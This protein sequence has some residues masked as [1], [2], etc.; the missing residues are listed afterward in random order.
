[1]TSESIAGDPAFEDNITAGAGERINPAAVRSGGYRDHLARYLFA[2]HFVAGRSVADL[3]CGVGYGSNLLLAA[4]AARVKGIDIAPDAVATA[5]QHYPGPEF[6]VAAADRPLD[7]REFDV[8]VC[9]EGIE[10]VADPDRLLANMAGA[11]L[12]VVSSPNAEFFSGGFSGN[13]HH[14][15]E[16]T[17]AEFEAALSRHFS[18]V[19]MY[20]QWHHPDPLDLDR[21]L[22]SGL[23]AVVPVPLKAR[24]WSLRYRSRSSEPP[25]VPQMGDH[26]VNYRVLRAG[27]LVLA[28]LLPGLRYGKPADWVALCRR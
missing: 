10:H 24:V 20:F 15:R 7:L 22:M 19:R 2:A 21:S 17:R 9:L 1:M 28:R 25:V 11:D 6:E 26:R 27:T 14:L 23:K 18:Q 13:P 8:A 5:R 4:G 16:W 3:C 12:A